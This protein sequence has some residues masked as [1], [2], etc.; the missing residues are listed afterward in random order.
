LSSLTFYFEPL[1][2]LLAYNQQSISYTIQSL[3]NLLF[4]GF[5]RTFCNALFYL[6]D[7]IELKIN[8][9]LMNDCFWIFDRL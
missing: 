8:N 1:A 3:Y 2:K 9:E 4:S 5:G 6:F 7:R